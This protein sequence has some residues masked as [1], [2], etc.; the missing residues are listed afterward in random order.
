MIAIIMK[1]GETTTTIH[2]RKITKRTM[3]ESKNGNTAG[4][5]LGLSTRSGLRMS[6]GP[7][8]YRSGTSWHTISRNADVYP[9][10]RTLL[11]TCPS[12]LIP[13]ESHQFFHTFPILLS[14]PTRDQNGV[15]SCWMRLSQVSVSLCRFVQRKCLTATCH[16]QPSKPLTNRPTT[17]STVKDPY[18]G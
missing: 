2:R 18:Y 14:S 17:K 10:W 3:T 11:K 13:K 1:I 12:Y 5:R 4:S 6:L 7:N 8:L 9:L 15:A 16:P